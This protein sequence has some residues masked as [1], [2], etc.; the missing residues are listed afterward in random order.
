MECVVVSLF[1]FGSLAAVAL[2]VVATARSSKWS[3]A[4]AQVARRF[5]GVHHAGGWFQAPSVWLKHGE[6]QARLTY[7]KLRCS[8]RPRYVQLAIQQREVAGRV[9][10]YYYQN[11]DTLLP[12]RRGLF[13]VE[14]DWEDFRRRWHVL[15]QDGDETR[16]LL[17]DG[18]RLAIELVWRQPTPA[19][20][21]ISLA[22]GML[23]IRKL[24]H[25]PR[26]AELEAFVERALGLA[27]QIN[28]ACA[29]GIEF[30]AGDVPQLLEDAH[31]GVCGNALASDIVVCRRCNTPHHRDCWQYSGGCA[32]YG[33]GGRECAVPRVATLADTQE[34]EPGEF[35]A[36][37]LKPR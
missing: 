9:E 7:G 2:L 35:P 26:G 34:A 1:L 6:A 16:R 23:T 15:A 18:V 4:L 3:E 24:W 37:P 33:C 10:I 25:A 5:H 31:C 14:F 30:V 11:R 32:T 36:K 29:A 27:D 8:G 28:L 12:V 19:E 17:S 13:P 22:P 20:M 21:S